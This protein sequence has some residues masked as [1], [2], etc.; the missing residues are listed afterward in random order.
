MSHRWKGNFCAL[1]KKSSNRASKLVLR[2]QVKVIC[3]RIQYVSNYFDLVELVDG[4]L[5][6][7]DLLQ[8]KDGVI[9]K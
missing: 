3:F 7:E 6:K 1:C 2:I 8:E 9:Q 4:Y 5:E